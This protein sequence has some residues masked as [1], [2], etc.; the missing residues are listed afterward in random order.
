ML[1]DM[2]FLVASKYSKTSFAQ[3]SSSDSENMD[4]GFLYLPGITCN[5]AFRCL[6]YANK[7]LKNLL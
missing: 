7:F 5:P 2:S 1:F 6:V 3:K 4:V